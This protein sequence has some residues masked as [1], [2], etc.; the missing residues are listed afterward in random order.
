MSELSTCIRRAVLSLCLLS[1]VA[2]LGS[3]AGEVQ[4]SLPL[5]LQRLHASCMQDMMKNTCSLMTSVTSGADTPS[6]GG[7]VFVAGVGAID[8]DVYAEI[9][10]YGDSMC[11]SLSRTCLSDW[12]SQSC[13]V[14]RKIYLK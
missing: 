12:S 1:S 6:P 5:E 7:V 11:D 8:A 2:L 10:Q 14:A 13:M 4:N 9:Y 3:D